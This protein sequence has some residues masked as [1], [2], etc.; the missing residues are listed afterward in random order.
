MRLL[1]L[2]TTVIFATSLTAPA[3]AKAAG[4]FASIEHLHVRAIDLDASDGIAARVSATPYNMGVSIGKGSNGH[5]SAFNEVASVMRFN[6]EAK[7][8]TGAIS[9]ADGDISGVAAS[10][11]GDIQLSSGWSA[12]ASVQTLNDVVGTAVYATVFLNM[13]LNFTPHTQLRVTGDVPFIG[14]DE[15]GHG[16]S[17]ARTLLI[18]QGTWFSEI[19]WQTAMV[20]SGHCYGGD[21]CPVDGFPPPADPFD[22]HGPFDFTL[23][24]NS[25]KYLFGQMTF[26]VRAFAENLAAPVPEPSTGVMLLG[27]LA[28]LGFRSRRRALRSAG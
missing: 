24:N 9:F 8:P 27:G 25:D 11:G 14:Y 6:D 16:L 3:P 23:T 10:Y 5:H 1:T 18:F 22:M 13:T 4:A 2:A 17:N 26:Q 28:A 7:G 20:F 12:R 21:F 19:P 15:A